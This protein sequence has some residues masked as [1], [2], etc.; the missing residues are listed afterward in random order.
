VPTPVESFFRTFEQLSAESNAADLAV[1]YASSFLLPGPRARHE[2]HDRRQ[3]AIA[4]AGDFDFRQFGLFRCLCRCLKSGHEFAR[5][6]ITEHR[7]RRFVE[8]QE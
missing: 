8:I 7:D 6:Q 4:P 2:P 5:Y 3:D 1:L